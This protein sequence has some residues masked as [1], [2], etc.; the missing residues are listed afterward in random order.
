MQGEQR[1]QQHCIAGQ[2]C[3][4]HRHI[5]CWLI[6]QFYKSVGPAGSIDRYHTPLHAAACH[7]PSTNCSMPCTACTQG[8][9]SELGARSAGRQRGADRSRYNGRRSWHEVSSDCLPNMRETVPQ[10]EAIARHAALQVLPQRLNPQ[11]ITVIS[12]HAAA[13][14]ACLMILRHRRCKRHLLPFC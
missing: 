8:T 1:L 5:T 4:T 6:M 2:M 3:S 12:S 7:A 10:I 13:S 14:H 9:T 11:H